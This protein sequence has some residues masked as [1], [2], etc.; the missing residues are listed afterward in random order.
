VSSQASATS[1]SLVVAAIGIV[2][3]DIGTS[4]LYAMKEAFAGPHR[5]PV[6]ELH[7]YG[8]LSL[9]FWLINIVVTW[10][11]LSLMMRADNRGEGGSLALLALAQ[12]VTRVGGRV[13]GTMALLGIFAAALFYG[14][15]ILTPAISVLSAVEGMSLVSPQLGNFIVPVTIAILLVL[16]MVQKGGTAAVGFLFGPVMCLWFLTLATMGIVNIIDNPSVL[17]ALNP[18]YAVS[19][20]TDN[21]WIAFLALGSVVLVVTGTEALYADMGHFGKR[22]IMLG[23]YFVVLPGLVI[24]YFGQG[25]LLLAQPD[26]ARNPFYLMAPSWALIPLIVMATAATVIASQAVISGSFSVTRQAIQ[27]NLLPRMAILHTSAEAAGQIYVP[28]VNWM[29][30]ILI[31]LLIVGFGSSSNLAGAYGVA[32]TGTMLIDTVLLLVVMRMLWKW[33]KSLVV[34]L[35]LVFIAIDVALFSANA[36]KIPHGGWFP[37]AVA[38]VL[39]VLLTTWM[40]GRQALAADTG[41]LRLTEFIGGV[42]DVTRVPGTAVF[43]TISGD[44]VPTALLHNLKHNKVLHERVVI[45]TVHTEDIPAV[46]ED[47]RIELKPLDN[48]F[49]RLT[50]HFGFMDNQDVPHALRLCA[51]LGLAFNDLETSYFLNRETLLPAKTG[52]Q[53]PRWRALLFA[54]MLRNAATAMDFFGL[55]PNRVVELGRQVEL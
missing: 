51:R 9:M 46:P 17:R 6:D 29:L 48:G 43:M 5:L 44:G 25:A 4:P 27:L 2:F 16:F 52:R 18:W 14:D 41:G 21:P 15:S 31:S 54:W 12:R 11:Y 30:F 24:N 34:L 42:G 28:F 36:I 1:K 33:R 32:V 45:L 22:P 13:S 20:I 49:Y 53:L 40:R 37:L 8:V 55:P 47:Q 19:F 23:W 3:G 26:A 10:K 7:V 39:F 50:L 38:S 35:A